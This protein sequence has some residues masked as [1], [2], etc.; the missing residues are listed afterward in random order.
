MRREKL[1]VQGK[2]PVRN[3]AGKLCLDDRA[4]QAACGPFY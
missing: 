4:K 3:D 1:D 2:K